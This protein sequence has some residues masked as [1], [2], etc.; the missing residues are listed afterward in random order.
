LNCRKEVFIMKFQDN[1]I[2]GLI[3]VA[4]LVNH[5]RDTKLWVFWLTCTN[6]QVER[7]VSSQ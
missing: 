4:A 2:K 7:D 1:D 3:A 6:S 5:G